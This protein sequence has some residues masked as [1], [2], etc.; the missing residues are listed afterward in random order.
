MHTLTY[1]THNYRFT[2][3]D[4]YACAFTK[5]S[6]ASQP[7][8]P[9]FELEI[10]LAVLV[11]PISSLPGYIDHRKPVTNSVAVRSALR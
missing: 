7:V 6:I 1:C 9:K 2:T 10:G 4:Q 5:S 3:A 8:S 11:V